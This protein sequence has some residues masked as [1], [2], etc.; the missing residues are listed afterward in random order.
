M[1]GVAGPMLRYDRSGGIRFLLGLLI[2][3]LLGAAV[4][5]VPVY[6]VS[7]AV[8]AVVPEPARWVLLA[9]V[10]AGFALADFTQRTPHV[11]RQVPQSLVNTLPPGALGLVW[12]FDLALLFTTQKTTSLIWAGLAALVLFSPAL[13]P[14]ALIVVAALAAIS[15]VL[16]S[17]RVPT[18]TPIHEEKKGRRWQDWQ[19]ILRRASG[20]TLVVAAVAQGL[21]TIWA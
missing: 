1:A 5:A 20:T 21:L 13:V 3:G 10:V 2:G 16:L 9:V 11:W 8:Q 6:L 17:L 19:R 4:L 15:M 14:T 12:G 7:V 18:T